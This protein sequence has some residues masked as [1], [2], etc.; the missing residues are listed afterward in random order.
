[1]EK[2]VK[3]IISLVLSVSIVMGMCMTTYAADLPRLGEVVDDS[4]LTDQNSAESILYNRMRGNIL[5]SGVARIPDTGDGSVNA[6]GAALPAVKCD[7]LRLE[8]T[9]ESLEGG[10]WHNVKSYSNTAYNSSMLSKS[11]NYNVKKGYYYR[12]KA[13][14]I[15]TK[16]GTTESQ[17]P[18]TDGIWID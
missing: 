7:S 4:L 12:V 17:M 16:G 11:Y 10:S 15:A 6:Y 13:A 3:R 1:M 18:I 9:I 8:M 5:N 2:I 14:C